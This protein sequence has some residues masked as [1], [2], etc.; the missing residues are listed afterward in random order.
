MAITF[1]NETSDYRAARDK[2]LKAEL[3][4]RAKVDEIAGLR[5]TLPF[6]GEV[7]EDYMFDA[8]GAEGVTQAKI[9]ELFGDKDDLFLYG[10]M[11]GPEMKRPCPLCT[12]FLS[13]F[14]GNV[15]SVQK[16]AAV[17]VVAKSPIG[18]V[19]DFA[20]LRGWK[21]LPLFSSSNNTFQMDYFAE[22]AEHG[23][24]PMINVFSKKDGKVYHRWG[25][26]VLY[27]PPESG[28]QPRH[29]DMMWP[30]WN[31]LDTLPVG[32]GDFSPSLDE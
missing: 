29:A 21:N 26:E 18:R 1:P 25:T 24:M 7:K 14:D 2:L 12:S 27:S 9:S 16:R 3:E 10:F 4:L 19:N 22:T 28:Q 8:Q 11:F 32:R 6:G 5:R 13:S 17:A 30:L 23:Q 15:R 31:V 20:E